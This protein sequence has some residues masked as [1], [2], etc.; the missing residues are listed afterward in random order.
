[1]I[2]ITT[3]EFRERQKKYFDL[4]EKERVIIKRGKKLVELVVC[5]S[6]S[7]NPSPSGDTWFD[8]PENM[9]SVMRGM[10]DIK[11]GRVTKIEDAKNIWQSI[12]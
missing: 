3:Q 4:A 1:M 6:L 8:D 12:L 7:E 10:A 9:A 5:D 11:A 2:I